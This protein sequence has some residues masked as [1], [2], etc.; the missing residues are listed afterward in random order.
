MPRPFILDETNR[1]FKS[2]SCCAND[3]EP[4]WQ[5]HTETSQPDLPSAERLAA[6]TEAELRACK[7]GFR[8]PNLLAVARK[9]AIDIDPTPCI[10]ALSKQESDSPHCPASARKS[11]TVSCFCLR[12]STGV[13]RGRVGDESASFTSQTPPEPAAP[14]IISWPRTSVPTPAAQQ[15]LFHYVRTSG[16]AKRWEQSST[17]RARVGNSS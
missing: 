14:S 1:R 2:S 16:G 5:R 11:P 7:M 9:V 13:S 12:L 8:A 17:P 10:P 3:S 4:R 15:Y 6:T